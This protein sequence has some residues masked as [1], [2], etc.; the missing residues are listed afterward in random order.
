MSCD[1]PLLADFAPGVNTEQWTHPSFQGTNTFGLFYRYA[2]I[3]LLAA[4][5]DR[6]VGTDGSVAR[7]LYFRNINVIK[8]KVIPVRN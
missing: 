4:V 2:R 5:G 6:W 7:R 1:E 8:D 3:K